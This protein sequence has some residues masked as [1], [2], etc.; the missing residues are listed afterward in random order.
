MNY[1]IK[2]ICLILLLFLFAGGWVFFL[3]EPKNM[4]DP[5]NCPFCR[6]VVIEKQQY[7]ESELSRVFYNHKPFLKGH[8]LILPKR[9]VSRFEDLTA[10][11][12]SDMGLLI[13][14]VHQAF[15]KV[16]GTNDYL[17]VLQNGRNA[18]Q[19]V[20]HVHMHILPREQS[21][22]LTKIRLWWAFLWRPFG[23]LFPISDQE[24]EKERDLLKKAI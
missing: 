2:G 23:S 21:H 3:S 16:Y 12:I 19:T 17:L 4:G 8:S 14:K 10:D 6:P 22:A 20:F 5:Q 9:H 18:G 24:L 13:K 15:Q 1:W 7:Y 11:E